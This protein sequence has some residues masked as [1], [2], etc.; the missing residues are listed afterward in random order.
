MLSR[1][2][3]DCS[4]GVGVFVTGL[5]QIFSFFSYTSVDRLGLARK[6]SE[7]DEWALYAEPLF[8]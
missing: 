6:A 2:F 8:L 5:S 3:L 4:V 1:Y 7:E